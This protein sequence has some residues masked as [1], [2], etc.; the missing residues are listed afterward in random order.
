VTAKKS[1]TLIELLM[2]VVIISI[3]A[4]TAIPIYN[5]SVRN[6]RISKAQHAIALIAQAEKLYII[7]EDGY[8]K[9]LT[10]ESVNTKIGTAMTGIDLNDLDNDP[11]WAYTFDT[12]TNV[13]TAKGKAGRPTVGTTVQFNL[14]TGVFSF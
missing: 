14:N 11:D 9:I 6:T 12:V 10:G 7:E 8:N 5:N 1:F 13:I 3:L 4:V 2:V